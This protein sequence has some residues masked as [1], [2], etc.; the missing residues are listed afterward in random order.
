M[1]AVS[2]LRDVA[3]K[4]AQ[5]ADERRR[6]QEVAARAVTQSDECEPINKLTQA[7]ARLRTEAARAGL[8]AE[9]PLGP[10]VSALSDMLSTVGEITGG[11]AQRLETLQSGARD[12]A[13][14]EIDRAK[15]EIAA[16]ESVTIDRISSAIAASADAALIKRVRVFDRNTALV[17]AGVFVASVGIALGAGYVWG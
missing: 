13:Q 6:Q 12:L 9:D 16:T 5:K 10:L 11:H 3:I 4:A 2:A 14:A 17:A 1:A 15:A 8:L 7:R